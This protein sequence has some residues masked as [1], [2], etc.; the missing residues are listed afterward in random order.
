M[1]FTMLNQ[2]ITLDVYD[3][4][5]SPVKAGLMGHNLLGGTIAR[6]LKNAVS[7]SAPDLTVFGNPEV[8]EHWVSFNSTVDYF[9]SILMQQ[10]EHT[11]IFVGRSLDTFVDEAHQPMFMSTFKG[12]NRD[13]PTYTSHGMSAY[14][15]KS[16]AAAPQG[17]LTA[18]AGRFQPSAP[19][20]TSGFTQVVDFVDFSKF[21]LYSLKQPSNGIAIDSITNATASPLAL[22]GDGYTTGLSTR[23]WCIGSAA[24]PDATQKGKCDIGYWAI[25]DRVLTTEELALVV[26]WLRRYYRSIGIVL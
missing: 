20:S 1:G 16:G 24:A 12:F 25:Y 6:S 5:E 11:L 15:T 18:I 3:Y 19:T 21:G 14:V 22:F 13:F 26:T 9:Q 8:H 4:I 7:A 2:A 23:P 10:P 17:K